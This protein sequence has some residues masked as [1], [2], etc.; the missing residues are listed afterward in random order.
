MEYVDIFEKI[1]GDLSQR[2]KDLQKKQQELL[3]QKKFLT[4]AK[5][6]IHG[7]LS[8]ANEIRQVLEFHP[9]LVEVVREELDKI[10]AVNAPS[11]NLKLPN[12][13]PRKTSPNNPLP[14]SKEVEVNLPTE[15]M[16]K[17][18]EPEKIQF[19][20]YVNMEGKTTRPPESK[21]KE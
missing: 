8:D 19:F 6:K 21:D 13:N 4:E 17:T 20:P 15:G 14:Q 10:F 18:K 1:E 9:H 12:T 11:H 2:V 16:K 5:Q 7:F 3:E